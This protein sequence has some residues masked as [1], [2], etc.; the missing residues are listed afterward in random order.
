MTSVVVFGGSATQVWDKEYSLAVQLGEALAKNGYHV[1]N[2]GYFGIMGAVSRGAQS[3]GGQVTGVVCETFT[4]RDGENPWLTHKIVE[5][6]TISRL[7]LMLEMA[8]VAIALPGKIGTLN[9]ILMLMTLWKTRETNIPLICFKDPFEKVFKS[10]AKDGLLDPS[11]VDQI[12]FESD[13]EGTI[14]TLKEKLL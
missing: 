2:G 3:A 1:I 6:N 14:F 11:E 4:F 5:K 9:E 10:L 12:F 13:L 8:D 7:S